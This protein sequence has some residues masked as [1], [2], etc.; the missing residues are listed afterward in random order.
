MKK[1][2]AFA[3]AHFKQSLLVLAG[4]IIGG[5]TM[6]AIGARAAIP[7]S[8]GT[9]HGCRNSTTT[10]LRVIDS[11]SQSCDGNESSLNWDQNGVKGYAYVT[12]DRDTETFALDSARSK[13]ISNFTTEGGGGG[14]VCLTLNSTPHN[15]SLTPINDNGGSSIGFKDANGW[16]GNACGV[17]GSN[18]AISMANDGSFF[19]TLY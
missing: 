2:L 17:S 7:D 18:V 8:D 15:M 16:A 1:L 19:V 5:S 3:G 9:I 12:Y 4:A 14:R 13:N 11:A 6:F 10:L